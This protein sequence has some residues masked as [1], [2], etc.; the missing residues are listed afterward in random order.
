MKQKI[1]LGL[2]SLCFL[3]LTGCNILE[4]V[5]SFVG[6]YEGRDNNGRPCEV[7][8]SFLDIPSGM[9]RWTTV[10]QSTKELT[11]IK[12]FCLGTTDTYQPTQYHITQGPPHSPQQVMIEKN[13]VIDF[14]NE[15]IRAV[16]FLDSKL[17]CRRLERK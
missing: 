9:C 16:T 10:S 4:I 7:R 17:T 1:K 3:A 6:V 8:V 12:R 15:K 2:L 5:Q 14:Q 11:D 13:T